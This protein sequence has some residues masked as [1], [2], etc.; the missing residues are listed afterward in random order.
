MRSNDEPAFRCTRTIPLTGVATGRLNG[1][2]K[3]GRASGILGL[4]AL[5][6]MPTLARGLLDWR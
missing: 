5:A 3:V 4:A 6:L 1:D 2:P